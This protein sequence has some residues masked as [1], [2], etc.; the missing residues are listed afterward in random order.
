MSVW[1]RSARFFCPISSVEI[2]RLGSTPTCLLAG[3]RRTDDVEHGDALGQTPGD[4]VQ[5]GQLADAKGRDHDREAGLDPRVPVSRV[6]RVQLV[7]VADPVQDVVVLKV[8]EEL[9]VVVARYAEDLTLAIWAVAGG[10]TDLTPACLSRST[11]YC[12][13]WIWSCMV[14]GCLVRGGKG[15]GIW[16]VGWVGYMRAH[17]GGIVEQSTPACMR[18]PVPV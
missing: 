17:G 9:E 7:G 5:R 6:G 1:W 10:L 15:C 11:M 18:V 4:P 12:A 16:D 2:A 13:R 8:V 14:G 3:A